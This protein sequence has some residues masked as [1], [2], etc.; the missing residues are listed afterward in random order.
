MGISVTEIDAALSAVGDRLDALPRVRLAHLPT[1]LDPLPRLVEA[2]GGGPRVWVKRDDCTGLAFGGNKTRQLEY[3]LGDAVAGGADVLIQGAASQ[4]NHSRQLA[5]A[6]A[7]LGLE[8]VLTPR[9]DALYAKAQGNQLVWRLLAGA[10]EPVA[11]ASVGAAKRAL[12]ERL[13]AEGRTPYIVGMGQDR[14]LA[15]AAVAYVGALL[16]IVEQLGEPPSHVYTTSQ[17]STQAGLQLGAAVLGLDIDVVGINPM[18]PANEA[19]ISAAG[20]HA[21]MAEG[22]RILGYEDVILGP[23]TNLVDYVGPAYGLASDGS[24]EAIRLAA[25]TE[26]LLVDPVYSG[27]GLAGLIDHIRSGRLGA[28]DQVVFVHTGGLPALFVDVAGAR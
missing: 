18:T 1:P 15:L 27:K 3:V 20:I 26:G 10:I 28:G 25:R 13:R 8:C 24:R 7:K 4:S 11:Q 22:A 6:A 21:L 12:A 14:A 19:Y 5:A 2:L 16:E 9:R 17:G 23:V